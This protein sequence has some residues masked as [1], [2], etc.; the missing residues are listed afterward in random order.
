[1]RENLDFGQ[2]FAKISFLVEMRENLD[3]GRNAQKISIL[4]E[5]CKKN[6]DFRRNIKNR[7]FG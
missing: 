3:F 2:N 4:V 1:M 5:I 6:P 7:D